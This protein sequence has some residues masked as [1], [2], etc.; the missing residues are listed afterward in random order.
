MIEYCYESCY[1]FLF[2]VCLIDCV[3]IVKG[4]KIRRN[5]YCEN[6]SKE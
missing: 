3:F 4:M 2:L 1:L 6:F 5:Y